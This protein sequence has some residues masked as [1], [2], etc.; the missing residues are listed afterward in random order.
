MRTPTIAPPAADDDTP[1]K[2][3]CTTQPDVAA[4]LVRQ[5]R[6]VKAITTQVAT[7]PPMALAPM[8]S[9]VESIKMMKSCLLAEFK[10]FKGQLGDLHLDVNDHERR[11]TH[12]SSYLQ[13]QE[14]LL[15]GYK[16]HNNRLVIVTTL[17]MDVNDA[18]A[19]IPELCRELVDSTV[20]LATSV[21]AIEATVKDLQAQVATVPQVKQG[22]DKSVP[23]PLPRGSV[24]PL[25]RLALPAQ[26]ASG[27]PMD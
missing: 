5:D 11:L 10:D 1:F 14:A 4:V 17:R 7:Q 26:P 15:T 9:F 27:R 13:K 21:K 20:G 23:P 12:L 24:N 16:A 8:T 2:A 19:K 22:A 25:R 18:C 6:T 3:I